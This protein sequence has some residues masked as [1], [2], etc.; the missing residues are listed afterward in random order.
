MSIKMPIL[1]LCKAFGV[2]TA[3]Y[4]KWLKR[5]PTTND[6]INLELCDIIS[7]YHNEHEGILGYGRMTDWINRDYGYR[8]NIKRYR[9]L[10]KVLRIKS[11]IRVKKKS[12]VSHEAQIVSDNILKRE[13]NTEIPNEKWLTDV[14][15]FKITGSNQK[16]YLSAIMDLAGKSIVS[17]EM[18]TSNNNKLVL[19]TFDKAIATNPSAT[20][21]FH[22]DRGS[23]YT[24]NAFHNKLKQQGIT[25]SM[26]RP[27]SCPDNAP[28]EAF[29]GIIKSEMYYLKKFR[30]IDELSLA[31]H[32]YMDFYNNRRY[33]KKLKGLTPIE[34]RN[35][36]LQCVTI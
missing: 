18:G 3:G 22:S 31:I 6:L 33:Q 34:F 16:L 8:Y 36:A 23:Q 30:S 7:N 24:S 17:Y 11:V 29:W 5:K 1:P 28:I 4:Y 35:Q 12:Y 25:Q 19:D 15:E 26:S 13:F 32:K 2:S 20:P 27:G 21:L 10:M 9:R 14:T